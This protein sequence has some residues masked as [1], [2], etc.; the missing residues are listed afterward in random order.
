MRETLYNQV[1]GLRFSG[2]SKYA[3]QLINTPYI[4]VLTG[5][6]PPTESCQLTGVDSRARCD[7]VTPPLP[8]G[9]KAIKLFWRNLGLS[10]K[11]FSN[12]LNGVAADLSMGML[13]ELIH[14]VRRAL[15]INLTVAVYHHQMFSKKS[16]F[17]ILAP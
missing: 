17:V 16:L 2:V 6:K 13:K 4:V 3:E 5:G 14:K 1:I 10:T 15:Q 7:D 9:P 8:Q 11:H 12:T